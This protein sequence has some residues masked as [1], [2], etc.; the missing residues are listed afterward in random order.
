MTEGETEAEAP[1]ESEASRQTETARSRWL[2][3]DWRDGAIAWI[4]DQL[5][6]HD[7]RITGPIEQP[8]IRP[9]STAMVVPTNAGT[10][11]FKACGP[12]NA[13]EATLLDALVRWKTP[14]ILE[15]LAVDTD[16]GWLLS[17]D[18]GALLRDR[19]SGGPGIEHWERILPEWATIQR[20]LAPRA[21]E[22][23]GLGV[24]DLRPAVLPARLADLIEDLD[25]ELSEPD[26][27]RLRALGPT[28]TD[29]CVELASLDIAPSLQHDDL[30]DGNVFVGAGGDRIFDWGDS[31]VAHPFSTLLVTFRSIASRGLGGPDEEG[32]VVTRLR[33]AYL[34]PWTVDHAAV[35]LAAAVV[36][37]TRVAMLGRAL[38]WQRSLVGVPPDDR[39]AWAGNVGGWLLELFEPTPS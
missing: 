15:P 18:G 30:H 21:E 27:A 33:D 22:M 32:R 24:P 26:Q 16:R 29:R 19:L 28:F 1:G 12:G 6:H 3:P 10:T 35:D 38:S 23:V 13:Y 25:T 2:D 17:P 8:R 7:L 5:G 11:W 31:S 34:E 14:W 36:N 37:A 4:E 9:W 20:H 39:G